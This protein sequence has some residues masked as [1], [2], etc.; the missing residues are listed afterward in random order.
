M[1]LLALALAYFRISVV[2]VYI[3][4]RANILSD[5]LS[6]DDMSTFE[7]A[8]AEFWVSNVETP[9][10]TREQPPVGESTPEAESSRR[11]SNSIDAAGRVDR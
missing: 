3:N 8:L 6:R 1:E 10:L 2:A 7:Q 11:K 5:A 9:Q 4:T